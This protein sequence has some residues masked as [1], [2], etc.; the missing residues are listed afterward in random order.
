MNATTRAP[1]ATRAVCFEDSSITLRG[2]PSAKHLVVKHSGWAFCCLLLLGFG[3]RLYNLTFH[4]LWLDEAVSVYLASFPLSEVIRQGMTLQEPNPPLYHLSLAVWMRVFGSGEAAIRLF[5]AFLGTLYL[6]SI[7]LLGR[8]LFSSRLSLVATLLAAVNPFLVWYSQEARMYALVATLSVWSVYCFVRALDTPRWSWWLAYVVLTVSSLYT[9]LY[10]V[11]VLP[12]EFILLLLYARRRR[13]AV[14]QGMFCW[15]AS[16]LCFSPWLWRAWQ[17]SASTPSWRPSLGLGAMVM[18][19]LEAFT[20]RQVPW[21]GTWLGVTLAALAIVAAAGILLP[22]LTRRAAGRW[23]WKQT[24]VRARAFL[25]LWLLL[26]LLAAYVLSFR[27]QIFTVYYLIVI[28]APLLLAFGAGIENAA[29]LHKGAG[30]VTLLLVLVPF[31]YGLQHEWSL[32]QRKEEWRAAA[33]YVEEHASPGDAVLCHADYVRIPFQYYFRGEEPVFAPFGGPV[34]GA[35]E[36]A[37]ALEGLTDFETVWLVQSHIEW[38]DPERAVEG[39]LS[40]SFPVVTE[41]YPPGVEVKAYAANYRPASVPSSADPVDAVYGDSLRLV[42]YE[43]DDGVYRAT[44]DTYHPPSGWIHVTLYWEAL[45]ELPEDYTAMVRVTDDIHQVW[46]GSLER[47]GSTMHFYP[48]SGWQPGGLVRDDYDVNLN[49]QTP[50]GEYTLEV[51]LLT[52]TGE[53]VSAVYEGGQG[54]SVPL[55]RVSIQAF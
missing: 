32:E 55:R 49:P 4:S 40:G 30:L 6:P 11:F 16:L 41:Q 19:C 26:P 29:S 46:G 43:V 47:A 39:W 52:A 51:S 37:G 36:V 18:E 44:D 1:T 54:P 34:S 24:D 20:V 8:R 53:E 42:A 9:H 23:G 27:Q 48:T 2:S 21:S 15:G 33:R 50:E 45:T 14:K 3:I 28:V 13:A 38:V 17:L 10:A 12:A 7:Y 25:A 22:G 31:W 35:D 5:S